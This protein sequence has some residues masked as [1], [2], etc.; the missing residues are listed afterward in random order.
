MRFP[1]SRTM[2]K[3]VWAAQKTLYRL[4]NMQRIPQEQHRVALVN[5]MGFEGQ[6]D[7][8]RTFQMDFLRKN[9]V[10]ETSRFLEIGS[11]PLTLAIPL[12]QHLAPGH[13]TGVDVRES[14]TNLAYMEISRA[15]L[16]AR[17]P[18]LIV[19]QDFGVAALGEETFDVIWSFSVLYHLR[20]DLVEDLFAT[21][22]KRLAPDGRYWANLND[23]MSE[24]DWLEFPFQNRKVEFYEEI[25]R[26]NGLTLTALG[27]IEALGFTGPGPEKTNVMFEVRHG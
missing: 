19:A 23:Q 15:G 12:M 22:K 10:T 13:Y 2:N 20:D 27:T 24:G 8:H 17:N 14:V 5:S 25:A 9:G 21:V 3:W 7:T 6:W 18:R 26:K 16:S 4:L 11:G 1:G